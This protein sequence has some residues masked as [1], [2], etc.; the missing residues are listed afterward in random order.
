MTGIEN[1]VGLLESEGIGLGVAPLLE[2]LVTDRP[3]EDGRM[4]AVAQ[5]Q[6]GEVALMP[7]VEEAGIVVLCLTASPHVEALVHYDDAHSVAHVQ[8]LGCGRVMRAADG[9]DTHGLELG[10]FAME[11]I[12]VKCGTQATEVVVLADAIEF[13]VLAVKPKA[14][15]GV[16]FK[17]AETGRSR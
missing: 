13:E 10:E 4:I 7:L 17:I 15:L 16:E 9:I 8:Q 6:V 2:D 12:F 3:H 14:S 11:G 5:H 1:E